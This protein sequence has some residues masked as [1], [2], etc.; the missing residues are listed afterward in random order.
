LKQIISYLSCE[1]FRDFHEALNV[2]AHAK[3]AFTL[4]DVL[5]RGRRLI[6]ESITCG[7]TSMRAHVEVD[8]TVRFSC[9]EAALQL[10]EEFKAL[11]E[12]QIAGMLQFLHIV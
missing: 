11:C 1:A 4:E 3:A 9:L 8:T 6:R 2:T 12:I 10:K 7:V 5:L